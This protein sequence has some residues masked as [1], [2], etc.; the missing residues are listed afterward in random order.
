MSKLSLS[1]MRRM[2]LLSKQS[3]LGSNNDCSNGEAPL[4]SKQVARLCPNQK[5][6]ECSTG[7][8]SLG[9]NQVARLCPNQKDND[10]A[11]GEA[12]LGS[13]K[14]ARLCPNQTDNSSTRMD[15]EDIIC[16]FAPTPCSRPVVSILRYGSSMCNKVKKSVTFKLPVGHVDKVTAMCHSR[17]SKL[18]E[19]ARKRKFL[20]CKRKALASVENIS[21]NVAGGKRFRGSNSQHSNSSGAEVEIIADGVVEEAIETIPVVNVGGAGCITDGLVE[22]VTTMISMVEVCDENVSFK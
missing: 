1:K 20:A 7:D 14:V 21:Q 13:K 4:G 19:N 9:S 5:D 3:P 6:N 8:R 18:E 11:N 2:A 10:S 17:P 15:F 22:E 16:N 12:S